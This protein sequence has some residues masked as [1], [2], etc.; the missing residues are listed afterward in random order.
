MAV[1]QL[2]TIDDLY[3]FYSSKKK[4]MAF[5][6]ER[7]GHVVVVQTHANFELQD[8]EN[9]EGLLFG[10][11]RAFHDLSNN[12]KS[13]IDTEVLK[14]KMMSLE[15]RPIMADIIDTDE[16]DS[17]G[18][19]IRDFSGHT[20]GYDEDKQ[21][22]V[23]K[24]LPVGHIINPENIH[25]EY[26][27]G[28]ERN[29]VVSDV[30]IYEEYT[31]ACE[32]MRR[33]KSVDCSV[34]LCIREMHWDNKEHVLVL[35][36]FYAQGVTLLGSNVQPGMQGSKLSLKDFYEENNSC[37]S[38]FSNEE[39]NDIMNTLDNLYQKLSNF[40]IN[41][42]LDLANLDF[43]NQK[44]GGNESNMN[45]F[46]ELLSKYEKTVDDIDFDYAEMSDEELESKFSEMFD[47]DTEEKEPENDTD[48][49][50]DDSLE[51]EVPEDDTEEDDEES[52]DPD[53]IDEPEETI[54][55]EDD[56][57]EEK[58]P[59]VYTK[60]FE[61][62]HEDLRWS[63]Y[64]L[65]API[66]ESL[67]ESYYIVAT[68]DDYFIYQ[69][70]LGNY[71]KQMYV[72]ENDTVTFNGER[73]EVYTCFVTEEEKQQL[74]EMRMNYSSIR[75][76]L[77]Q[78]KEAES[79]AN[80]MTVFEDEAYAEYLN[81]NEFKTL[82]SAD[83]VKQF[84][85]EELVEKADSALGKINRTTKTFAKKDE[86]KNEAKTPTFFAFTRVERENSFLDGLLKNK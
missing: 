77:A 26:D 61:I 44:E 62:S 19:C 70:C 74:E 59:E 76:E 34:E 18:N 79:I 51:P 8:N 60:T 16:V 9:A 85:K 66:E 69:S 56:N 83:T 33:R 13:Y 25:L 6:S 42:K 7:S 50:T 27:D 2:L 64:M 67:N 41:S 39:Y 49:D 82:M 84:T 68:Y 17:D 53:S 10:T 81:T 63:L 36:D 15:N 47:E 55:N 48:G 28:L 78:Y 1:K 43:E 5:S 37:F 52:D 46:E 86:K 30:V 75:S 24:E 65:L 14:E 35:D 11:I 73:V 12:N 57:V 20:M 45:K 21:K 40:N 29:F 80:K 54:D 3:S 72:V 58:E 38:S 32:I 22:I 4:S 71:Y 23:Y 31:D